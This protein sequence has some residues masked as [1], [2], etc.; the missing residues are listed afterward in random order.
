[1][2]TW[3][4]GVGIAAAVG[5]VWYI[6]RRERETGAADNATPSAPATPTSHTS[7]N[8]P[9]GTHWVPPSGSVGFLN[10]RPGACV[11]Q[12]QPY[13]CPRGSFPNWL[14]HTSF[15]H[16]ESPAGPPTLGTPSCFGL[17]QP[18]MRRLA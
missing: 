18:Q 14:M 7:V 10:Y 8:C 12:G 5:A 13:P 15:M 2:S 16:P 4:W 17:V 1:M 6:G 11:P 9:Q 3:L